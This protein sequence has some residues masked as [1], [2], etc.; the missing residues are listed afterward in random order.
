V[1]KDKYLRIYVNDH[2]AGATVGYELAKRTHSNNRTGELGA[3][4][5]RLIREL[6][7]DRTTLQEIMTTLGARKDKVKSGAAWA[8]EKVGRLKL[9]GQLRGY[10]DLS[11]VVELEALSVGVEG[12]HRLW[13]TLEELGDPRLSSID[14]GGLQ[15]RAQSQLTEL[16]RHRVE[17]VR[18]ALVAAGKEA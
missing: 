13:R 18:T 9:N 6:G 4:L 10:S 16:E 17:A 12:K 3:F 1:S 5:I 11:R 8:A 7:E 15:A 14:F 2:L